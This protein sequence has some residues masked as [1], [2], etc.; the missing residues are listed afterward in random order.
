[1]VTK[2]EVKTVG[3]GE[4]QKQL[5]ALG[6]QVSQYRVKIRE[7][8]SALAAPDVDPTVDFSVAIAAIAGTDTELRAARAYLAA[9]ERQQAAVGLKIQELQEQERERRVDALRPREDAAKVRLVG[10]YR[11]YVAALEEARAMG[12]EV[13]QAGGNTTLLEFVRH[14]HAREMRKQAASLK[15]FLPDDAGDLSENVL[16]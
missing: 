11:A 8:E 16:G 3:V 5:E 6:Q 10:A 12:R 9:T 15:H 14:D 2:I 1:M 7:L 13:Q 4:L